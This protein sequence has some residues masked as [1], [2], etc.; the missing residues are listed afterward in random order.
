MGT[1]LSGLR[2]EAPSQGLPTH[3]KEE[4]ANEHR[5][6]HVLLWEARWADPVLP[7]GVALAGE[8]LP[9]FPHLQFGDSSDRMML[10]ITGYR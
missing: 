2:Q 1:P 7:P 9:P 10:M 6:K 8:G 3:A 4:N 5:K